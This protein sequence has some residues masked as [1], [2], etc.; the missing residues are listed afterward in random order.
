M[1]P[2]A[3]FSVIM[4]AYWI[5]YIL[6]SHAILA[7]KYRLLRDETEKRRIRLVVLSLTLVV[8]L[9]VAVLVYYQPEHSGGLGAKVF[10]SVT[11]RALSPL[12]RALFP[13]CFAYAIL[14][15]RLF[16]IRVIIRQGIRYAA[17][18]QLLLIAAPAILAIFLADFYAHRNERVDAIMHDRGWIYLS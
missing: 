18:K 7:V 16:D 5:T 10:G 17:A 3:W 14:R 6:G 2:S 9:F 15:H 4:E 1:I 13:L 11:M 12:G 8:M